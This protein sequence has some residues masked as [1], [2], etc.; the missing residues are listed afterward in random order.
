ME[1]PTIIRVPETGSIINVHFPYLLFQ[2]FDEK[3]LC[4]C[5]CNTPTPITT[6]TTS[7]TYFRKSF[8]L[9]NEK[10]LLFGAEGFEIA[11]LKD[12][13]TKFVKLLMPSTATYDHDRGRIFN[14][15]YSGG[16]APG[17]YDLNGKMIIKLGTAISSWDDYRFDGDCVY[18]VQTGKK[19]LLFCYRLSEKGLEELYRTPLGSSLGF[20]QIAGIQ[21]QLNVI[22]TNSEKITWVHSLKKGQLI[23]KL[24][25]CDS[26]IDSIQVIPTCILISVVPSMAK[27]SKCIE[28]YSF[29][30]ATKPMKPTSKSFRPI[31]RKLRAPELELLAKA[32]QIMNQEEEEKI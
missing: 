1:M 9:T 13:K 11:T 26:T 4:I 23:E 18:A 21:P 16:A 31:D 14:P 28:R 27:I 7:Q 5:Q 24:F 12:P 8:V 20:L 10:W 2:I 17:L 29:L 32:K 19:C 22:V 15:G 30:S 3:T 6:V 25:D